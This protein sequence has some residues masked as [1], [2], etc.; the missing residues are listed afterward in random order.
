MCT[1]HVAGGRRAGWAR[2]YVHCRRL[3]KEAYVTVLSEISPQ[4]V[5]HPHVPSQL[6]TPQVWRTVRQSWHRGGKKKNKKK[7]PSLR[8]LIPKCVEAAL[9]RFSSVHIASNY[10]F[11]QT[12]NELSSACGSAST[13]QWSGRSYKLEDT[14]MSVCV[15]LTDFSMCL[16]FSVFFFFQRQSVNRARSPTAS[17]ALPLRP[18]RPPRCPRPPSS[19]M[20]SSRAPVMTRWT[21]LLLHVN[22]QSASQQRVYN[23]FHYL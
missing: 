17:S 14:I 12:Y 10:M 8:N 3:S 20:S 4:S 7:P 23:P 11:L 13:Q 5:T 22:L 9:L 2:L 6:H 18:V 16:T 15:C 1:C 19:R 21:R